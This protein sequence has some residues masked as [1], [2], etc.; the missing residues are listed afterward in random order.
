MRNC[1]LFGKGG[2]VAYTKDF[3]ELNPLEQEHTMQKS[4][5]QTHNKAKD[6]E[7]EKEYR[8]TNLFFPYQPTNEQRVIQVP[9][10]IIE[11]VNLGMN[12]SQK[13]KEEIIKECLNK[14]IK[15]FQTEKIPFRFELTRKE[16]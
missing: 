11:E 4:F 9:T 3:P 5:K 7:Y 6:W 1:G 14:N 15:V 10:E 13:N 16:I 2:P 12:I 8:L